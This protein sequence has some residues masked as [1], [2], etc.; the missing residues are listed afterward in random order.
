MNHYSRF[1]TIAVLV[2]VFV[3]GI[4]LILALPRESD[5]LM[6]GMPESEGSSQVIPVVSSDPDESQAQKTLE[7]GYYTLFSLNVHDWTYSDESIDAIRRVLALHEKYAV[8]V[9]I[10]FTDPTFRIT[11]EKAPDLVDDLKNSA[12]ATVAY[13]IRPPVPYYGDFDWLGLSS[14]SDTELHDLLYAYETHALDLSTGTSTEEP[15]G[16]AYVKEVMGYAPISVG[17]VPGGRVG[18]AL[19]KI[20]ADMGATFLVAHEKDTVFGDAYGSTGLF[21]RP[22][23]EDIKIY[24]SARK[25]QDGGAIIAAY[26]S[27][28]SPL[29][30]VFLGVKYHEDNFYTTGGTPWWPAFFSSP[31]NDKDAGIDL[32]EPPFPL[33]DAQSVGRLETEV[34]QIQDWE[35]Y[36]SAVKYV[37]Q[38]P[39]RITPMNL[40]MIQAYLP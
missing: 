26:L 4:A 12:L 21:Y 19:A 35:L 23:D 15:G 33:G 22:E 32:R 25:T 5:Q 40:K 17:T 27:Q 31:E 30:P 37:S 34:E 24:E 39:E 7:P 29:V 20:Y 13:H 28:E 16:Y 11:L 38:H 1:S 3:G 10:Y 2:L 8:P 9:D 6:T 14:L 18:N 36:E